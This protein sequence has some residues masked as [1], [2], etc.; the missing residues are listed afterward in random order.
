MCSIPMSVEMAEERPHVVRL[1]PW[2][3]PSLETEG[4][5][6]ARRRPQAALG[7]TEHRGAWLGEEG[8]CLGPSWARPAPTAPSVVR[9]PQHGDPGSPSKPTARDPRQHRHEVRG[10]RR[11]S[12]SPP[13][14]GDRSL[15]GGPATGGH[16]GVQKCLKI[17][18][19]EFFKSDSINL[20]GRIYLREIQR[21]FNEHFGQNHVRKS[22][23]QLK[24][25][26]QK[27]TQQPTKVSWPRETS[28]S[29]N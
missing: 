9:G 21:H 20:T 27:K 8:G 25:T 14:V 11:P 23:S 6:S 18:L 10:T 19:M 3:F 2:P 26:K 17:P 16:P 1:K 29:K 28:L 4:F 5:G 12:P 22:T 24:K 13:H 15:R 7:V